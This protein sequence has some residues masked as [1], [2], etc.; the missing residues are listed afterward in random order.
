MDALQQ[1]EAHRI[2]STAWWRTP[3]RV[4]VM[5]RAV[6]MWLKVVSTHADIDQTLLYPAM[7]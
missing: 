7:Y 4:Q 1:T 2:M 6:D 5:S 3:R